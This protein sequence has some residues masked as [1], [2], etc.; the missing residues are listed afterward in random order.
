[1]GLVVSAYGPLLEY[2]VRRYGVSLPVAGATISVHF[3]GSLPGVIVAMRS[4]ERF[5]ARISVMVAC[6]VISFGLIV[7]ALAFVWPLF[8]AG[9]F[10]VGFGFGVLVLGLNQVV[11]YSQ[12]ARRV[13][14]LNA[15][16]SCFSAGAVV[17]PLLVAAFAGGHFSTLFLVGAGAWLL[18]IPATTGIAG[19]LPVSAGAP[20]WPGRLVVIFVCAF[21]LYVGI[22]T[23]T[24]G[25]MP[26]HLRSLGLSS[27][28]A[29]EATSLFFLALVVGRLLMTVAPTAVRES[30]IVLAASALATVAL[31]LANVSAISPL[32][33]IVAGL[34]MAP[35]FPTGILWLSKLRPEDSRAT[36]WL[37]PAASIGGTLGPGT[38]GVVIA[39]AGVGW[40]PAVLAAV[41]VAMSGA[42]LMASQ[43]VS[44]R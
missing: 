17:G 32:A 3:A 6:A 40:T 13:G 34:A 2:L 19:R 26:S 1:M 9:V 7:I 28:A 16:N 20:A 25:W 18:V 24:A 39:A 35:I 31:L 14:L 44:G 41:A 29:A 10:V 12:G 33:Y 37:Y 27:T 4:F 5:Q 23:G 38:I 42:F 21:V 22:E 8:L 36:S 43:Q 30:T 11:A 15:L